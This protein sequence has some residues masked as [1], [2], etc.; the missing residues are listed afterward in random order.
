MQM[1][2]LDQERNVQATSASLTKVLYTLKKEVA[3]LRLSL[4]FGLKIRLK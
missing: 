2:L 3:T 1:D 4:E